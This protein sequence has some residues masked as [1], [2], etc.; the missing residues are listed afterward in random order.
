MTDN[1]RHKR[2]ITN[3]TDRRID[4]AKLITM[5]SY[6]ARKAVKDELRANGIGPEYIASAAISRAAG[7]YLPVSKEELI[8]K[9]KVILEH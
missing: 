1:N 6:L 5:A 4:D 9:A 7:A 8:A 2:S 3:S